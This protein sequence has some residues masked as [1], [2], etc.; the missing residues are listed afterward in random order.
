MFGEWAFWLISFQIYQILCRRLNSCSCLQTWVWGA[1]PA[2]PTCA[3]V[4]WPL[5][6]RTTRW[7]LR[8]KSHCL[9]SALKHPML[10]TCLRWQG[11]SS[12]TYPAHQLPPGHAKLRRVHRAFLLRRIWEHPGLIRGELQ[13]PEATG[14][15]LLPLLTCFQ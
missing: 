12:T 15:L 8:R 14:V 13:G 11:H 10:N 5:V 6:Q 3:G 7:H 1:A 9:C 4:F 2:N